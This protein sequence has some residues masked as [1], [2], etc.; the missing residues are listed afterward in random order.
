MYCLRSSSR[1]KAA[2]AFTAPTNL[3]KKM[4]QKWGVSSRWCFVDTRGQARV[5][6]HKKGGIEGLCRASFA[7]RI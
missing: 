1:D 5:E 6:S 3:L 4:S 2:L 7:V